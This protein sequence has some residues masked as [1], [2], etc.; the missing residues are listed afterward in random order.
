M[1]DKALERLAYA[2]EGLV[3][4]IDAML[5]V[6]ETLVKLKEDQNSLRRDKL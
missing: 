6:L 5:K 2:T 1:T 3:V 4:K